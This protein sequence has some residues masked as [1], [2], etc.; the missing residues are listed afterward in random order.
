MRERL[1]ALGG[2]VTAGFHADGFRVEA[3]VP[4]EGCAV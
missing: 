1:A 3:V 2:T 4:L